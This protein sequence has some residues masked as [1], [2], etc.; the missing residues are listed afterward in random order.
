[1][2]CRKKPTDRAEIDA[3]TQTGAADD[4]GRAART[5]T[6]EAAGATDLAD[7]PRGS[8]T[9]AG[10]VMIIIARLNIGGPASH[11]V[12]LAQGLK[13]LGYEVDLVCG[14]VGSDEGDMSYYAAERGIEP[15]VIPTLRRE[16]HFGRD[17]KALFAL[18]RLIRRRRPDIVHTHTA[19][20]GFLGRWAARACGIRSILHTYHGHVFHSYFGPGKTAFFVC[21]ERASARVTRA[22]ITLSESLRS[23]LTR[24]YHIARP[25]AVHVIPLGIDLRG[26]SAA[27]KEAAHAI[28][29]RWGGEQEASMVGI[30]GRLVP[31][32]DHALFLR[33]AHRTA[34]Q[35]PG[36]RFL[37]VGDGPLRSELER[38]ARQLGLGES[39]V[40]T[41]WVRDLEPL[42]RAL[43]LTVITSRNEGTPVSLIEALAA[44][45]PVVATDVG[46]VRDLLQ[47]GAWGRLVASGDECAL[48]QA[49]IE[50]LRN[51]PDMETVSREVR[52]HYGVDPMIRDTAA[53]YEEARSS[54]R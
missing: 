10:R 47:G 14:P 2:S 13:R 33:A 48:A 29:L 36:A 21:L 22:I 9:S 38:K 18:M 26:L 53:L 51:P 37:I 24:R 4:P 35:I 17:S 25:E 40:F 7:V 42:Y 11:V 43:D 54:S 28:R 6:N 49:M 3:C 41:G 50:V 31:V 52:R 23:E 34:E 19:K 44:Q 30:V 8:N 39:A 27:S 45:C 20:A 16:L 15:I 32:K 12:L 1:M 46:G 5:A